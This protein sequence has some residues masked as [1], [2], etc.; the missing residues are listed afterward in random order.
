[1]TEP[2][3]CTVEV[4]STDDFD[5]IHIPGFEDAPTFTVTGA[6]LSDLTDAVA[7]AR[8]AGARGMV[9][10]AG[11]QANAIENMRTFQ[12]SIG[13][14]L[15]DALRPVLEEF[16]ALAKEIAAFVRAQDTRRRRS[17]IARDRIVARGEE[18]TESTIA[19]EATSMC[20]PR[21]S[22]QNRSRRARGARRLDIR[23]GK[24]PPRRGPPMTIT[25]GGRR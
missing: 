24:T 11:D 21:R 2:T 4:G 3:V 14:T 13:E 1:M 5:N 8:S 20:R 9:I 12:R 16:A 23:T 18:P 15:L 17:V 22:R 19:R 6:S 7:S 25:L 10:I